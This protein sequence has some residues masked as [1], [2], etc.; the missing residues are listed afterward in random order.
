MWALK[1]V[2]IASSSVLTVLQNWNF[3]QQQKY[4]NIRKQAENKW[5]N[6]ENGKLCNER[7]LIK[8]FFGSVS[9]TVKRK[10]RV[11]MCWKMFSR[12]SQK[13][14]KS[15]GAS[16]NLSNNELCWPLSLFLA[17][18]SSLHRIEWNWKVHKFENN[19][20]LMIDLEKGIRHSSQLTRNLFPLRQFLPFRSSIKPFFKKKR[21]KKSSLAE[22]F[23]KLS[24]FHWCRWWCPP[25][26][27]MKLNY[28][29]V[30]LVRK[31]EVNLEARWKKRWKKWHQQL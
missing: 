2:Q 23:H 22:K 12:I 21:A 6:R 9:W 15:A 11:K 28:S 1:Q 10:K 24:T 27:K 19:G 14:V 8:S 31:S 20:T 17:L 30:Q 26:R 5:T 3:A 16:I 4:K 25:K 7:F 13:A 18:F 29:A